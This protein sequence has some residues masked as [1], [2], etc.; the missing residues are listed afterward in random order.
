MG[1]ENHSTG[2]RKYQQLSEAERYKIVRA[3]NIGYTLW[4]KKDT[5]E[6]S[7]EGWRFAKQIRPDLDDCT[8]IQCCP[9]FAADLSAKTLSAL[10][11]RQIVFQH[12]VGRPHSKA[13][14]D[15]IVG[16]PLVHG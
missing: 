3:S 16:L 1:Q 6:S 13:G 9:V 10:H 14:H 4:N 15:V 2:R 8:E 5:V 7:R 12:L 11:H